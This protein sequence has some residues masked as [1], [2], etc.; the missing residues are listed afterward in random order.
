MPPFS[1]KQAGVQSAGRDGAV[2]PLHQCDGIALWAQLLRADHRRRLHALAVRPTL[3]RPLTQPAGMSQ[4]AAVTDRSVRA[5][6][7][8]V[9]TGRLGSPLGRAPRASGCG[10]Q[11]GW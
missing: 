7:T 3:L 9:P 10:R 8:A 5:V 1:A 4:T 6:S 11:E 2:A